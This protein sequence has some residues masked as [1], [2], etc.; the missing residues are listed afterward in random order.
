MPRETSKIKIAS[1]YASQCC[2]NFQSRYRSHRVQHPSLVNQNAE[3]VASRCNS[4]A[5]CYAKLALMGLIPDGRI[6]K[7]R[8]KGVP[9]V[10]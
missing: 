7:D 3:H 6:V 4:S 9:L 8:L 1:G 10:P 2:A 5:P